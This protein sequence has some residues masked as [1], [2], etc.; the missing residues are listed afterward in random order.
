MN[1]LQRRGTHCMA[2]I[3]WKKAGIFMLVKAMRGAAYL[4]IYTLK[5]T[6]WTLRWAVVLSVKLNHKLR[7]VQVNL[8][9]ELHVT[10]NATSGE[11][12]G[13]SNEG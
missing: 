9:E 12:T 13:P 8:E 7:V 4:S 5:C 11:G 3:N 2:K 6:R 10:A 1:G